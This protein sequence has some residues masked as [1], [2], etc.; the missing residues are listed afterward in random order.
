MIAFLGLPAGLSLPYQ[1]LFNNARAATAIPDYSSI[2]AASSSVDVADWPDVA[3]EL[4]PLD[5]KVEVKRVGSEL[6]RMRAAYQTAPDYGAIS[7]AVAASG[8]ALAYTH[9]HDA[10]G[11]TTGHGFS[12][13][14]DAQGAYAYPFAM[15]EDAAQATPAYG[16]IAAAAAAAALAADLELGGGF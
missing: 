3:A 16:N 9:G 14:L 7:S 6:R 11:L 13:Q 1:N 10:I 8:V 15:W 2:A 5:L 4:I 12:A